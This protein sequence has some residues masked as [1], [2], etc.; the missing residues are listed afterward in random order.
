MKHNQTWSK[1]KHVIAKPKSLSEMQLM[2]WKTELKE[3]FKIVFQ[4][5]RRK[6]KRK[7]G[8]KKKKKEE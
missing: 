7:E 5:K 6:E 8:R 3:S 4:K 2:S 1:Y